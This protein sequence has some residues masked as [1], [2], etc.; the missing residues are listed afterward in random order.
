MQERVQKILSAAGVASRRKAE[1]F[2][3]Q[4]RVTVNGETAVLGAVADPS[5]DEILLDGR[6]IAHPERK[7]YIMLHKPRGYV[8]TLHDEKGRKTVCDL[9]DCGQRVYPVGRLDMDSEGL[10]LMT[11]DGGTANILLHP[12]HLVEKTYE[13]WVC[14][15]SKAAIAA[16]SRPMVMDGTVL[17]LAK[18]ST[19]WHA[20]DC[21]KLQV[22]IHQGKN[23]QIRRMAELC[24]MRVTRLRRISE[25]P[26]TLGDLKKGEWRDL[27]DSERSAL[28]QIK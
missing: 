6:Q 13:V 17:S 22:T 16:M 8:T 7:R 2:I 20:E 26:L 5:R 19:L 18:I 1:E 4:G 11:N 25:G 27:T 15:A 28:L 21:A 9:V 23:R 10:L 14:E 3:R 24:G 12:A